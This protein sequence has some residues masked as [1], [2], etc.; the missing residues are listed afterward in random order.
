[1][2]WGAAEAADIHAEFAEPVSYT[3]AGLVGGAVLAV[4]FD[5]GADPFQGAGETM[6][7][8]SYEVRQADLPER[9]RKGDGI[10]D[11]TG[12]WNVSEV[13]RRDDVGAWRLIVIEA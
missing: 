13:V 3:G 7:Q 10:D 8:V 6:R 1:V 11:A 9:P 2:N 5:V 12:S 4:R